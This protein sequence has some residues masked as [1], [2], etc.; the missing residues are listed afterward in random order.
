MKKYILPLASP[1][2]GEEEINEAIDSLRRYEV[3]MGKKVN[4]F[5]RKFANYLGSKHAVMVNSGSSANLL[6]LKIVQ[7][8]CMGTEIITPAITWATTVF[9]IY[10]VGKTPVFV[11]IELETLGM[12][13][14]L[15]HDAI[16]K[17]T[18]AILPVHTL[19]IPCKIDKLSDLA[20]SYDLMLVEDTAEAHGATIGSKKAGTFGDMGTFSFYFSHHISTIEGGMFVTNNKKYEQDAK[21]MREFGYAKSLDNAIEISSNYQEIDSRFLFLQH[22]YN[23]KPTEIQGAFGIHQIDKLDRFIEVRQANADYW[24]QRISKEH[25]I[26]VR[27]TGSVWLGY[28]LLIKENAGFTRKQLVSHLEGSGIETRP[29]IAGNIL[30]QPAMKGKKY[31]VH[32]ELKNSELVSQN[33]IYL[34][35]HHGIT[36]LQRKYL[37]Q[38]ID[39]FLSQVICR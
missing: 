26:P 18:A 16:D 20:K 9:P 14:E 24:N 10:D 27:R 13:P 3:T 36:D 35:V 19:G 31:K 39:A 5:E 4:L 33:G 17:D 22:G 30:H 38:T 25:F 15:V 12:H 28:P 1:G 7:K 6:A 2:Y 11:D 37:L 29:I 34:G 21:C 23:F 8:Y 32:G